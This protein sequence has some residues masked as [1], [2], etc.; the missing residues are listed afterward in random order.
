[1]ALFQ[2]R[3]FERIA[4]CVREMQRDTREP[5]SEGQLITVMNCLGRMCKESAGPQVGN[6]GGFDHDR[7]YSACRGEKHAPQR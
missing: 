1:M 5:F 4:Q 2:K 7:F 3:H 6:Y